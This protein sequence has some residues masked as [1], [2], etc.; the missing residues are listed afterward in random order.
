MAIPSNIEDL[1]AK[2]CV[3]TKLFLQHD[4][5]LLQL[6]RIVGTNR[7]YLSQYFSRQGVTY[8]AY[9]NDLRINHFM[10]LYREAIA[11]QQP[12]AAQQLAS[13]SGYRSSSTFCLAFKQRMGQSLTAW[14]RQTTE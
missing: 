6:A 8:N 12:I 9:I 7:Y 11:T 3:K 10:K 2:R 1:L 13:K 5:T 4:L 14:M